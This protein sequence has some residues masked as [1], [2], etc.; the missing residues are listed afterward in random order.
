M[1]GY[2]QAVAGI[3]VAVV[4]T[5][6]MQQQGKSIAALLAMAV[7]VMVLVLGGEYLRPVLNFAQSLENLG[8]LDGDMVKVLLKTVGISLIS[9]V[10]VLVCNDSGN[11]SMG[12]ALQILTSAVLLWMSLPAFQALMDLLAGILEGI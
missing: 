5:L 6:L 10:A 12:K 3:L 8:G 7:C 1:T 9:E 4:L 2:F 11:Q